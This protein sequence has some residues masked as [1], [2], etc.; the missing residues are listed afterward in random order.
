MGDIRMLGIVGDFNVIAV[1]IEKENL[2]H[3][4]RPLHIAKIVDLVLTEGCFDT[5]DIGC[6]ER[7]VVGARRDGRPRGR[8]GSLNDVELD[9]IPVQPSAAKMEAWPTDRP[10]AE[11]VL[12][13]ID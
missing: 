3:S 5:L 6:V 8:D 13:E 7:H 10:K 2:D 9:S 1:G 12:V 11:N 4:G